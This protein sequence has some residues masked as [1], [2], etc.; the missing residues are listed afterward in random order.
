MST[1]RLPRIESR[2]MRLWDMTQASDRWTI[3]RLGPLGHSIPLINGRPPDVDGHATIR[4]DADRP[5]ATVDLSA[6]YAGQVG[7]LTREVGLS[8]DRTAGVVSDRYERLAEAGE[9]RFQMI[10]LAEVES[11][12]RTSATLRQAGR[13][14][15]LEAD[16]PDG[17]TLRVIDLAEPPNPWDSP[18]PGLK[19]LELAVPVEAGDDVTITVRL[20]P[21]G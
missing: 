19:R 21:A 14:L 20:V 7:R 2:G 15:R 8:D 16:T 11:T 3:L 10:T 17:A 6:P 18:N 12:G 4:R 5:R 9:V 1:E 13:T